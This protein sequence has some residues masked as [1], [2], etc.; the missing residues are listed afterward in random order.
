MTTAT[1][2]H[3]VAAEHIKRF[4]KKVTDMRRAVAA[5]PADDSFETLLKFIHQPGWTTIAEGIFFEGLVDSITHQSQQLANLH[6][7]LMAGAAQ[8]GR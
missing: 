1:A 6:S 3:G 4:D 7:Q 5:L 8:V 2:T